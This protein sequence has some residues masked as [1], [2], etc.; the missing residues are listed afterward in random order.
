M[1]SGRISDFVLTIPP[2]SAKITCVVRS[3]YLGEKM[4][5]HV[6]RNDVERGLQNDGE[7]CP[8]AN[9]LK[10]RFKRRVNVDSNG[11]ITLYRQD[12]KNNK[13]NYKLTERGTD[14]VEKFDDT[15]LFKP[16][17]YSIKKV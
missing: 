15:G 2:S 4:L 1:G 10:R 7:N 3:Q 9:A 12:V 6:T 16:G 14:A 8:V 5:I 13:S 11:T 17:L